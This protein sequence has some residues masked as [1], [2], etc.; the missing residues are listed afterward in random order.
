MSMNTVLD[1]RSMRSFL[2]SFY[3]WYEAADTPVRRCSRSRVLLACLLMRFG[4]LRLGEVLLFDD[5]SDI[6]RE[7]SL[8]HVRG[9]WSRILPLP[10]PALKRI[11]ELCEAPFNV[12]ERGRLCRLDPAY[13]RRVFAVRAGEAGLEGVSPSSLRKFREQELLRQGV[14]LTAAGFFLGRREGE[15]GPGEKEQLE[16]ACRQWEYVHQTGRHNMVCGELRVLRKGEFS[17]DLEITTEGGTNFAVRCST[18][19]FMRFELAA[20]KNVV[21]VVHSLQIQ[22]IAQPCP[23]KNCLSAVV[24]DIVERGGEARVM[25]ALK[26]DPQQCFCAIISQRR[27]NMLKL[28]QNSSVWILIRPEDVTFRG[29]ETSIPWGK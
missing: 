7:R 11:L 16:H 23:E 3:H 29:L 27:V 6:D 5:I 24:Q 2:Q 26:D 21:A 22:V 13:V 17:S 1:E 8:L 18:R 14:S 4:G 10:R 25:L 9:R 12:R 20:R 15:A 19:S 28:L